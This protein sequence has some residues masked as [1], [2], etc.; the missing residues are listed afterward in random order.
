MP[1]ALGHLTP[2]LSDFS[3]GELS[4]KMLGRSETE[5]YHKGAQTVQNMVPMIQGGFRKR[6]GTLAW[7]NTAGDATAQIYKLVINSSLWYL[8]EFTNLSL[9]IWGNMATT[10]SVVQTITTPYV[11]ADLVNFQL[12]W[13]YPDLFIANKKYAPAMLVYTAVNTFSF[14]NPIPIVGSAAAYFT[15]TLT[16]GNKTI[17]SVT[18]DPTQNGLLAIVLGGTLTN[19]SA[20]ITLPTLDPTLQAF[21]AVG[22]PIAGT[23][24]AAGVTILSVTASTLTMSAN[25]TGTTGAYLNLVISHA[26]IPVS[27]FTTPLGTSPAGIAA[28]SKVA[29]VTTTSIVMDT[30]ANASG[31]IT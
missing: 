10:P 11:S 17:A 18:P 25:Y 29:S 3:Y 31:T 5:V 27:G 16:S 1:N 12:G 4:P 20:V 8:L 6:V 24:I 30:N 7:G 9:R 23:G 2:L 22:M 13:A 28:N 15:G 19:G 26:G 14:V 21:S